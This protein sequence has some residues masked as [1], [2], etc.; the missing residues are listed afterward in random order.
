MRRSLSAIY[1]VIDIY[2][3]LLINHVN[4]SIRIREPQVFSYK[5]WLFMACDEKVLFRQCSAREITTTTHCVIYKNI[6]AGYNVVQGQRRI[7]TARSID[8]GREMKE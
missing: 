3:H 7:W 2:M 5:A 6:K 4:G 8:N 1:F